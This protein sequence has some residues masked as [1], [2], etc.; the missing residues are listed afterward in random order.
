MIKS[1]LASIVL[2]FT[3]TTFL[4]SL[5]GIP[6]TVGFFGKY[7][8]FRAALH[9]STHSG[10]LV[11]LTVIGLVNSA[12]ASY[13]Y[14]RLIVAMYM[15]EPVV[16]QAPASASVGTKL[17]LV[18]TAIATFYLGMAPDRVLNYATTAA[19]NLQPGAQP[20]AKAGG[21]TKIELKFDTVNRAEPAK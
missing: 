6:P 18:I 4:L 3:L 16:E 17:A 19:V 21:M 8:V 7:Y 9:S 10:A 13:Y 5:I 12:V 2:A 11:W 15:R 1:Y 20:A 14:L